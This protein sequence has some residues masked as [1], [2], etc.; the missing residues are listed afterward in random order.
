[1]PPFNTA[2]VLPPL[3][4]NAIRIGKHHSVITPEMLRDDAETPQSPGK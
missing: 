4:L 2:Q 1:M 3:Q